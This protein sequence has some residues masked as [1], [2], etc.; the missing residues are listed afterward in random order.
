MSTW[1]DLI[2]D[3]SVQRFISA[4]NDAPSSRGVSIT[5]E[6]ASTTEAPPAEVRL[7]ETELLD[8]SASALSHEEASSFEGGMTILSS[9]DTLNDGAQSIIPAHL[10]EELDEDRRAQANNENSSLLTEESL[11]LSL[12][13]SSVESSIIT[14]LSDASSLTVSSVSEISDTTSLEDLNSMND[15]ASTSESSEPISNSTDSEHQ[16]KL[17]YSRL[18]TDQEWNEFRA[19]AVETLNAMGCPVEQHDELLAQLI[20]NEEEVFWEQ[21][22]RRSVNVLA[23]SKNT[24]VWDFL[25]VSGAVAVAGVALFRLLKSRS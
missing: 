25:A 11:S 16:M 13:A 6:E 3:S 18:K 9:V 22:N 7:Y 4:G 17:W 8:S 12:R 14:E 1:H 15:E 20:A 21:E 2:D 5:E 19:S 23:E 10:P 24:W